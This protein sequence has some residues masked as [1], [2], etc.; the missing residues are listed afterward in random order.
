LFFLFFGKK[1]KKERQERKL[2]DWIIDTSLRLVAQVLVLLGKAL[3]LHVSVMFDDFIAFEF[4][5][6]LL[7]G[8]DGQRSPSI[9]GKVFLHSFCER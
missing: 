8:R 4:Q 2:F 1:N 3:F 5:A 9:R 6:S 7:S